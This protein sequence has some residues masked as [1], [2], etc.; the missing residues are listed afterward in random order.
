MTGKQAVEFCD[1]WRSS[2]ANRPLDR[3]TILRRRAGL[4]TGI[5]RRRSELGAPLT[6][7]CEPQS[8]RLW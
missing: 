8:A 3:A 5:A 4:A 2:T 1:H 7:G 6:A